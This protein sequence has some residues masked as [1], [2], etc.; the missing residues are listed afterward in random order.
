MNTEFQPSEGTS[1]TDKPT[2]DPRVAPNPVNA[3]GE[4][5]I[6][7]ISE[8]DSASLPK[9][10][11]RYRAIELNRDSRQLEKDISR[12]ETLAERFGI[13]RNALEKDTRPLALAKYDLMGTAL[14][15]IAFGAALVSGMVLMRS[16]RMGLI[17]GAVSAIGFGIAHLVSR[18]NLAMAKDDPIA[19]LQRHFEK[20]RKCNLPDEVKKRFREHLIV[21]FQ[22]C[23]KLCTAQATIARRQLI[24]AATQSFATEFESTRSEISETKRRLGVPSTSLVHALCEEPCRS[25]LGDLDLILSEY[26]D[27]IFNVSDSAGDRLPPGVWDVVRRELEVIR[28]YDR[29][30]KRQEK[31]QEIGDTIRAVQQLVSG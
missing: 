3:T 18:L 26:G 13:A 27:E 22:E 25:Y 29:S 11:D 7:T 2:R 6:G 12:Y 23:A 14:L 15:P 16:S 28:D 21:D 20:E 5:A 30:S 4:E 8:L 9:S 19:T 10:F 17:L 24:E 1:Y 31:L